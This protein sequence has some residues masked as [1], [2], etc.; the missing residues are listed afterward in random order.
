MITGCTF[1][2]AQSRQVYPDRHRNAP[3]DLLNKTQPRGT[4]LMIE[5]F[6]TS[7]TG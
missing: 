6:Q 7:T 2:L 1:A 5:D 3:R 4:N